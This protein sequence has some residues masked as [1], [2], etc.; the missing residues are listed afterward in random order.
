MCW[1]DLVKPGRT[2]AQVN[3]CVATGLSGKRTGAGLGIMKDGEKNP[4]YLGSQE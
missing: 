3:K 4:S 2:S 1:P